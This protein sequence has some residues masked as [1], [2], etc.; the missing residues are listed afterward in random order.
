MQMTGTVISLHSPSDQL[1]L[2][3]SCW[4]IILCSHSPPSYH[5]DI[6]PITALQLA[7]ICSSI[8]PSPCTWV[9]IPSG[10]YLLEG[11][12]SSPYQVDQTSCHV[13]CNKSHVFRTREYKQDK[14]QRG[15]RLHW[16]TSLSG[17]LTRSWTKVSH[18]ILPPPIPDHQSW[19][20]G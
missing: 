10:R 7:L 14:Q 12:L 6:P 20:P 2:Y 4:Q 3:V 19:M 1:V 5:P 17:H 8:A 16:C 15:L 9:I 13:S 18:R 11:R